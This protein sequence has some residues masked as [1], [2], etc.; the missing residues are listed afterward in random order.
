MLKL[1]LRKRLLPALLSLAIL[2]IV[3]ILAIV[4]AHAVGSAFTCDSTFYQEN[5]GTTTPAG[6]TLYKLNIPAYTYS[7]VGSTNAAHNSA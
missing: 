5:S 2:P 6:S 1:V 7:T 4:P 3:P